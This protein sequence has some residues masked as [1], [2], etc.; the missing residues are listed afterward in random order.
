LKREKEETD[1]KIRQR[2]QEL[3]ETLERLRKIIGDQQP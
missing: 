1:Q 3:E 2:N